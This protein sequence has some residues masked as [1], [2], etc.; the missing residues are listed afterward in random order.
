MPGM[1]LADTLGSCCSAWQSWVFWSEQE[2]SHM[3][4]PASM[5]I[6]G[7]ARNAESTVLNGTTNTLS[8]IR[9][10]FNANERASEPE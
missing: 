8:P 2:R 3:G 4:A 5:A 6:S 1:E 9:L 7:K 10:E